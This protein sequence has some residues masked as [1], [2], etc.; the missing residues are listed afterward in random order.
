MR[1]LIFF[2]TVLVLFSGCK[3]QDQ[4]KNITQSALDAN[5]GKIPVTEEEIAKAL[6]EAL[7]I[8]IQEGIKFLGKTNGFYLSKKFKIEVPKDNQDLVNFIKNDLG[9]E[10]KMKNFVLSMN[11][12]AEKATI[13]TLE[14]FLNAVK[15]MTL[16]DARKILLG[17][18]NSATTY[19]KNKTETAIITAVTPVIRKAMKDA[20]V[21]KT[22]KIIYDLYQQADSFL[23]QSDVKDVVDTVNSV[24]GFLQQVAPETKVKKIEKP[25]MLKYQEVLNHVLKNTLVAI[26]K[27]VEEKEIQIR[28]DIKQ[29]TTELLQRVFELYDIEIE[30][31]KT[32]NKENNATTSI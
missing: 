6:K 29:R 3:Y 4:L 21:E 20:D 25:K 2:I 30:L 15:N 17:N 12:A 13:N 7:K 26:F 22:Y 24:L 27:M 10:E 18:K 32:Q 1:K 14:I 31:I 8:G 5:D 23:N 28:E 16:Q 19:F 11:R 9:G